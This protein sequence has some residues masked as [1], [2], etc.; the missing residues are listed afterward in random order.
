VNVKIYVEGGG[1][2][3]ALQSKCREGFV[4]FLEKSGFQKIMP[5]VV[6][7]GSRT[8]AHKR[9]KLR[10]DNDKNVIA[11]LLIDSEDCVSTSSPWEHLSNREQDRFM[12]QPQGV[13]DDQCHLMVVCMESWFIADKDALAE[14]FGQG[15]NMG[16]LPQNS[17]I[18][19]VSKADIYN[20]I[21]RAVSN[22]KTRSRYKKRY[23]KGDHSFGILSLISP[24]KVIAASPWAKRFIDRLNTLL[25]G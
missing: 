12:E 20:G 11:L 14:F 10:C 9:F 8:E 7:C 2:S 16:A 15:F 24:E 4:G 18:E 3:R 22:C 21:Q 17:N 25:K 5:Q 6:P 23:S 19:A 1:D 13:G